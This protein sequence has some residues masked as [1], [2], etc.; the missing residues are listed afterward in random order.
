MIQLEQ[1]LSPQGVGISKS[2]HTTSQAPDTALHQIFNSNEEETRVQRVRRIMGASVMM[3]PDEE[4]EIYATELQHL[5][6]GWLDTFERQVF[7]GV[8]LK[9]L[10]GQG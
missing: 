3:L 9:Q 10:L 5:I 7:N 6:D 2:T 4:L 8:T 1:L